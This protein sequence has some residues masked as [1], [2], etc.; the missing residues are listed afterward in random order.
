MYRRNP[1]KIFP[2]KM[3]HSP[4]MFLCVLEYM[5]MGYVRRNSDRTSSTTRHLRTAVSD[6]TSYVA[7]WSQAS[8]FPVDFQAEFLTLNS[9]HFPTSITVFTTYCAAYGNNIFSFWYFFLLQNPPKKVQSGGQTKPVF[10]LWHVV[11]LQIVVLY[12]T[13]V[14]SIL[15]YMILRYTVVLCCK[16]G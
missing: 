6:F 14:L 13:V 7:H 4:P 2:Q 15:Y 11:S 9:W 10:C 1:S 3:A 12:S 16:E 8:A 5:Y